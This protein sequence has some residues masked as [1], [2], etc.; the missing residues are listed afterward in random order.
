MCLV[1]WFISCV[2][3]ICSMCRFDRLVCCCGCLL[4]YSSV[5]GGM[6]VVCVMCFCVISVKFWLGLGCVVVIIWLFVSN[7]LIVLG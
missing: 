5:S 1:V 4:S 7:V 6:S 3:L 2:L